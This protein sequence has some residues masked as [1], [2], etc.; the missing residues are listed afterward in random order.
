[1][2]GVGDGAAGNE[3]NLPG[4]VGDHFLVGKVDD[5]RRV[6]HHVGQHRHIAGVFGQSIGQDQVEGLRVHQGLVAHQL[7]VQ[8]GIHTGAHFPDAPGGGVVVGTGHQV[9]HLVLPAG[10]G[11]ALVVGGN[12]HVVQ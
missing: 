12:E 11:N 5:V 9:L 1:S 3:Q 2:F 10:F 7:Q 4:R 6:V 8:V